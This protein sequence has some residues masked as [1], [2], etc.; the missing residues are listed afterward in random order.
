[1]HEN[2]S[3]L[4]WHVCCGR[5]PSKR[6]GG[7]ICLLEYEGRYF[8]RSLLRSLLFQAAGE[9]AEVRPPK[10]LRSPPRY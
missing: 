4:F 1:M 3:A 10:E 7:G 5:L 6:E 2:V 9:E 8:L